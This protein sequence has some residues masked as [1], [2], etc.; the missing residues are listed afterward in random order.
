MDQ[1][2]DHIQ[3][4]VHLAQLQQGIMICKTNCMMGSYSPAPKSMSSDTCGGVIWHGHLTWPLHHQDQLLRDNKMGH[5]FW[6]WNFI[7]KKEWK[8]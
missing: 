6:E 4:E 1:L 8:D 2:R 3:Q 5:L 7:N